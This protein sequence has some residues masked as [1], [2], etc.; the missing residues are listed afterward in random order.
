MSRTILHKVLW[1][2]TP[3]VLVLG[4]FASAFATG[5]ADARPTHAREF[6]Y[7]SSPT[8]TTEVGYRYVDCDGTIYMQGQ[9]TQYIDF[10]AY[11]CPE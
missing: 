10:N 9:K 6:I 2:S 3:F 4:L 8:Y 5:P 11:P 7:Y 1:A